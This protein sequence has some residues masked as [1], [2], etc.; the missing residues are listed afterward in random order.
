MS[1]GT[2]GQGNKPLTTKSEPGHKVSPYLLRGH[3]IKRPNQVWAIDI[4]YIPMAKGFVYLAV[5]LDWFSRRILS[6][7]MSITMEATLCVEAVEETLARY[8]KPEV[9]NTDQGS[10][11]C[12]AAFTI[13]LAKTASRPA[14]TARAR[15]GTTCSSSGFG[16]A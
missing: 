5:L 9:F 3:E 11:F 2:S 16:A 12:R 6:W 10:Q 13:V 8:G 4:T 15:G 14:W 7:R 1:E